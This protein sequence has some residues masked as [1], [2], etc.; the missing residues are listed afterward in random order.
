MVNTFVF[1]TKCTL[2][3][4]IYIP[5]FQEKLFQMCKAQQNFT[6][7]VWSVNENTTDWKSVELGLVSEEKFVKIWFRTYSSFLRGNPITSR[8][9]C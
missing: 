3:L 4:L 1:G 2:S 5:I 7:D 6:L 8:F 9:E